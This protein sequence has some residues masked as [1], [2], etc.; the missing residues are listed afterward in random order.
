MG[1]EL[2]ND[3]ESGFS[4]RSLSMNQSQGNKNRMSNG[5]WLILC[6]YEHDKTTTV[7]GGLVARNANTD[8]SVTEQ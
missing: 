1:F 4:R 5:T 7:S 3:I 6:S 8:Y 2:F